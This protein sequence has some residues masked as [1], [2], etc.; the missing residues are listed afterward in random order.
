[1]GKVISLIIFFLCVYCCKTMSKVGEEIISGSSMSLPSDVVIVRDST[2]ISSNLS[3]HEKEFLVSEHY[4]G[5]RYVCNQDTVLEEFVS[6]FPPNV[7]K[8]IHSYGKDIIPYLISHIDINKKGI[9]GFVNPYESNLEDMVISSPMGINYAYMIELIMGKDSLNDKPVF[10][11]GYSSWE[12]RL[13]PYRLYR[14]CVIVKR[15]DIDDPTSSVLSSEDMKAI[16]D[17]YTNWWE[18]NKNDSLELLRKKWIE[19]GGPLSNTPY[20]W[21]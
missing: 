1:M 20:T 13:E 9:A 7:M 8:V 5:V 2:P 17:I 3:S 11:E 4:I 19:N 15:K 16:K 6:G 18:S 12:E 21:R 10:V 14:Q